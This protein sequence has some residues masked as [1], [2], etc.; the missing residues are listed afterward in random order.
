MIN[1]TEFTYIHMHPSECK[2][3]KTRIKSVDCFLVWDSTLDTQ[4]VTKGDGVRWR[5]S[6]EDLSLLLSAPFCAS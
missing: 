2:T 3:G 4:D 5:V 1:K 6:I